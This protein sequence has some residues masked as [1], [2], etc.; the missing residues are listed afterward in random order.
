MSEISIYN[1]VI[2]LEE[3]LYLLRRYS[4][5]IRHHVEIQPKY[6]LENAVRLGLPIEIAQTYENNYLSKSCEKADYIIWYIEKIIIPYIE[7]VKEKLNEA[8]NVK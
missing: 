4:D 6:V 2:K 7:G 3:L 5:S 1:Q 8:I